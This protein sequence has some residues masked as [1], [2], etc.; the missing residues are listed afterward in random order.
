MCNENKIYRKKKRR[1]EIEKYEEEEE[2]D[3]NEEKRLCQ[4][5][6]KKKA[7]DNPIA[8]IKNRINE[9]KKKS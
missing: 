1:K 7:N 8:Q 5:I 9:F 3:K 6:S 4:F 2:E